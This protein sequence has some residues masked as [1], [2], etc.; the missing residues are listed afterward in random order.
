MALLSNIRLEK[1]WKHHDLY[2]LLARMADASAGLTKEASV[3]LTSIEARAID[4]AFAGMEIIKPDTTLEY[5]FGLAMPD[6]DYRESERFR[7]KT[8]FRIRLVF[9]GKKMMELSR[10]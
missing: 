4:E 5:M 2:P 9:N 3:E 8:G 7:L 10:L 6:D 1:L